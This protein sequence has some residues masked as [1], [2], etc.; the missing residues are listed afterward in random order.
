MKDATSNLFGATYLRI[1]R[2]TGE[3][4][5]TLQNH[6]EMIAEFTNKMASNMKFMKKL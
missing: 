1:S 6:R 4:E 3:N 5:D 2:D